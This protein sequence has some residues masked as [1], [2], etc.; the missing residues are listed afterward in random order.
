MKHLYT[1]K[2]KTLMKEIEE[3]TNEWKA[4]QCSWI[5]SINIVKIFILPKVIYRLNAS[6][7]CN[8][9]NIY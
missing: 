8:I 3:D 4:F 9:L 2:H 1:E 5:G 7:Q 6:P